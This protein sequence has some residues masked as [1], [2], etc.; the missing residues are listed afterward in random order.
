MGRK[1]EL[2]KKLLQAEKIKAEIKQLKE[3]EEVREK[4]EQQRRI[5]LSGQAILKRAESDK[6]VKKLL[7]E[8]LDKSLTRKS[9]RLLFGLS[10]EPPAEATSQLEGEVEID[11]LPLFSVEQ[12]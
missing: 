2:E 1:E 4:R 3:Q 7:L 5:F 8:L 12:V 11:V 6:K 9:D 10:T